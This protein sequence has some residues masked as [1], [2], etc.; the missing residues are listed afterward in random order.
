MKTRT[1]CLIPVQVRVPMVRFEGEFGRAKASFETPRE[2]LEI[3]RFLV[4]YDL[5]QK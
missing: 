4:S 5:S 1:F 2:V 3:N